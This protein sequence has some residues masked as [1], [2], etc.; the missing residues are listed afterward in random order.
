MP[1]PPC[2]APLFPIPANPIFHWEKL[3]FLYEKNTLHLS[4]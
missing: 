4:R 1:G 2:S 3:G